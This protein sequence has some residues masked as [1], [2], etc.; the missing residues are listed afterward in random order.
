[1]ASAGSDRYL[2]LNQ[3]AEDFARRYRQGERPAIQEY[4][5]RYPELA[6]E[7]REFLPAMADLEQAKEDRL[8]IGEAASPGPPPIDRLGDFHLLREVGR[9][10]MGVVYEAEQQSLGRR[11][12]LKVLSAGVVRDG[13]QKRRFE[14]EARAAA[15]LHHTNIV[16]VFGFGEHDGIPYFVMQFIPGL[17]LD[18]V[19]DEIR[20]MGL[21]GLSLKGDLP[22]RSE[23]EDFAAVVARSLVTGQFAVSAVHA[24]EPTSQR[25][26]TTATEVYVP[27][28]RGSAPVTSLPADSPSDPS[29]V[30]PAVNLPGQS[31]VT[32][33][34]QAKK[35]SYWQSIARVGTQVASAVGYA[36]GHGVLHRDLKPSNLLL[37][38]E[39]N[40]WVAD[41]GL[42]KTDDQDDLT[43]TGDVL[44]TLRYMPPEAFE[45]RFD[46]R[47]DVY[48]LGLS[49]YEL[50]A[51]RP[52]FDERERNQ[53]IKQVTTG[54]PPR[55][56]KFRRD[57][58][59][60]L[61][62]IVEKAIDRDP[63]RRYATAAELAADLERFLADESIQA[64]RPSLA[65]RG[66][67][68]SRRNPAVAALTATVLMLVVGIPG[69]SV[70]A[71]AHF[72][73]LA[74]KEARSAASER[75]ARVAAQRAGESE[76]KLR[77]KTEQALA[78]AETQRQ[79]A[80]ANFA[81]ARAAVDD[82][83]T[84]V[85]E[86]ELLQVPSMQ[87]LRRDLLV[88]ARRFYEDFLK[89]HGDDPTIRAGLASAYLR[90][91]KIADELGERAP[92]KS[93][94]GQALTLYTELSRAQPEDVEF[95]H[96]TAECHL[97][98]G[99][100]DR[101]IEIWKSLI[102]PGQV[103]FQKDLALA[104]NA[105]GRY[106][107]AR[108]Q[109][110]LALAA[111]ERSLAIREGLLRLQ[112]DDPA[113]EDDLSQTLHNIGVLLSNVGREAEAKAMYS[114]PSSSTSERCNRSRSTHA[115]VGT[116]RSRRTTWDLWSTPSATG[117][118]ACA[119]CK[120]PSRSRAG[121]PP[122]I[123]QFPSFAACWLSTA[124]PS[125]DGT[126]SWDRRQK[127]RGRSAWRA[128]RSSRCR[129][130]AP[131]PCSLWPASGPAA[132]APESTSRR[133]S[134]PTSKLSGGAMP[135]SPS[136]R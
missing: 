133:R 11:V 21:P 18:K 4:V 129:R 110:A 60:D 94:L 136:K 52:A 132:R 69:A 35:L 121:L 54:E 67:R 24:P 88:S 12:A 44:G 106:H 76:A 37:D 66:W 70:M 85:S 84:R 59:R 107:S 17:G 32:G 36:H 105:L 33:G 122:R 10:G 25:G 97:L 15:K 74:R 109:F 79:R 27:P 75:A 29:A 91:G 43:H 72:D 93:A 2:L 63:A 53:L 119:R 126:T 7:I 3:L 95:L 86:S 62:T 47:G 45:G 117:K 99:Q 87:P 101:A 78:D 42:A 130:K 92:A 111:Y 30:P 104:E 114:G 58:P 100:F 26:V 123:R 31:A 20:R 135:I 134:A 14:R 57:V 120:R 82:Y 49:L 13:K 28:D 23:R 16:P 128:T 68:W 1:M 64:R 131:R 115:T 46:A 38:L 50:L 65:E 8:E 80:E 56:R 113:A 81:K 61:E 112:G 48:S 51:L 125:L 90:V 5:D 83:L 22:A 124:G 98:L 116:L 96:A 34:R 55:L 9:G 41:F 89:E 39:G 118:P 102:K 6:D 40:V 77:V 127:Q 19:I 103:R 73:A 108:K 71:A